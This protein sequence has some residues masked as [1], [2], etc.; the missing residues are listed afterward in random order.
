MKRDELVFCSKDHTA[1]S[2]I[3]ILEEGT[4]IDIIYSG[5]WN[6]KAYYGYSKNIDKNS[7]TKVWMTFDNGWSKFCLSLLPSVVVPPSIPATYQTKQL[8]STI[9]R[10]NLQAQL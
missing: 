2:K 9:R 1:K 8:L 10:T 6:G 7:F 4:S 3:S 5:L